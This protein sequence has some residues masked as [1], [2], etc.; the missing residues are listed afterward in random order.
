MIVLFRFGNIT[1]NLCW[2]LS[3]NHIIRTQCLTQVIRFVYTGIVLL[4]CFTLCFYCLYTAWILLSFFLSFSLSFTLFFLPL[5]P[6]FPAISFHSVF[7]NFCLHR[8]IHSFMIRCSRWQQFGFLVES[9]Y[10]RFFIAHICSLCPFSSLHSILL[11]AVS[12]NF[13]EM[14]HTAQI[15]DMYTVC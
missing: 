1:A 3:N 10:S 4:W 11:L 7:W 8:H 12:N 5:F 9:I 14:K 6:F 13:V 15:I 2:Y